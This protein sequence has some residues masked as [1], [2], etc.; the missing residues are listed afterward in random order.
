MP[1]VRC[2]PR[3]MEALF[4]L[5]ASYNLHQM[6]V[7]ALLT[8]MDDSGVIELKLFTEEV[9]RN[10][11]HEWELLVRNAMAGDGVVKP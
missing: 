11:G 6:I 5:P 2:S 3:V 1:D 10:L 4:G 8:D 9:S 7:G